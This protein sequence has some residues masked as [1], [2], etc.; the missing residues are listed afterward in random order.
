MRSDAD[1][2]EEYL[3][4]LPDDRRLAIGAVRDVVLEHLPKGFEEAMQHGA[5][6]YVVPLS[7]H[8]ETYNGEALA[9]ASLANQ[10]RYMALY[11]LGVYG[12]EGAQ[13]PLRARWEATGRKLDM[14]KSCLRFKKLD[15]LAL[16]IVGAVIASSS[17]DDLI[18]AHERSRAR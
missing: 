13:E 3:A 12:E 11:L 15:D 5:I 18:A 1:T 9:L 6:S 2:V 14:G 10:K 4:A 17:V 16:D 7:R 8:P